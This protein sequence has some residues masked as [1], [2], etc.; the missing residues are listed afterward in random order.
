MCTS[1]LCLLLGELDTVLL[2]TTRR[3]LAAH[4]QRSNPGVGN[5]AKKIKSQDRAASNKAG[6]CSIA[7]T[8]TSCT[9]KQA[10]LLGNR[11]FIKVSILDSSAHLTSCTHTPKQCSH[12]KFCKLLPPWIDCHLLCISHLF[13]AQ[14]STASLRN[15][16]RTRQV[17]KITAH[18][19]GWRWEQRNIEG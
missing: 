18:A 17:C 2:T 13:N 5:K 6:S 10:Q 9:R 4:P 19:H 8:L 1:H 15:G 12:L 14:P 7:V 11:I 3:R 16:Y